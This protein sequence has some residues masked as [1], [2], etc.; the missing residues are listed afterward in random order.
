MSLWRD[1][2]K[3]ENIARAAIEKNTAIINMLISRMGR[4]F[5]GESVE[6]DIFIGS[7]QS[8]RY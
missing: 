5:G 3:G 4:L 8:R 7:G 2:I 6:K 1:G